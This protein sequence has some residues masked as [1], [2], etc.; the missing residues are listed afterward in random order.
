MLEMNVFRE[1]VVWKKVEGKKSPVSEQSRLGQLVTSGLATE[2][3]GGMDLTRF[4]T[5]P[6]GF[7]SILRAGSGTGYLFTQ[8]LVRN[9]QLNRDSPPLWPA[10]QAL[11]KN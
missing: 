10:S 4:R 3:C 9:L 11:E 2:F 7:C 6:V 8:C 1:C 5:C